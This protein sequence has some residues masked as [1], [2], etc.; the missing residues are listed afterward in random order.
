VLFDVGFTLS[1]L[2]TFGL[3]TLS[4]WVETKLQWIKHES[5]R[6]VAATTIAVQLFVLPALLYFTGV[7]SFISLPINVLV[8][9]FVPLM[10]LLGF[11]S[12]LLALVHPQLALLPALLT[13]SLLG[14]LLWLVEQAAK[15]PLGAAVVPAFPAWVAVVAYIP[16]LYVAYAK[17]G[18]PEGRKFSAD[19]FS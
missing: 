17:L 15:L 11:V 3:V 2:A 18:L 12:G 9:P 7:L 6:A 16:L 5:V 13:D 1:V 4:P 14:V 8:L 10:M 19:K